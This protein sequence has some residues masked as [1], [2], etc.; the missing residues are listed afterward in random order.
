M[1]IN[2]YVERGIIFT[3]EVAFGHVAVGQGDHV[4]RP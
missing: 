1:S 2:D 3:K 4:D